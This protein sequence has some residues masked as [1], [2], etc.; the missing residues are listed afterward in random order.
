MCKFV[1]KKL[2]MNLILPEQELGKLVVV[3][4]GQNEYLIVPGDIYKITT[5]VTPALYWQK[6]FCTSTLRDTP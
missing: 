2:N 5:D 4:G 3:E 1:I 6:Y